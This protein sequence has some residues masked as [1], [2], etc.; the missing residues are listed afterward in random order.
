MSAIRRGPSPG[1]RQLLKRLHIS[2]HRPPVRLPPPTPP[3]EVEVQEVQ[4]PIEKT[5]KSELRPPPAVMPRTMGWC[6]ICGAA[7][8]YVIVITVHVVIIVVIVCYC[9]KY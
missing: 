4:Q 1:A 2:I 9:R 7:L 5:T 3:P 6:D 8:T